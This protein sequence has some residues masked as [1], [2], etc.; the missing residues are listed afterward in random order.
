[1][2]PPGPAGTPAT[3]LFALVNP[4]G[5]IDRSSHVVSA[6]SFGGGGY[7]VIFDRDVTQCAFMATPGIAGDTSVGPPGEVSTTKRNATPAGV[8]IETYDSTGA[9]TAAGFFLSVFCG[10]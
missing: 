7:E 4:D 5:T 8:Y 3:N 10:S 2:G 9:A 6:T 1:M